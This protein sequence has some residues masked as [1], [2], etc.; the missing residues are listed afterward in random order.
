MGEF[1][2]SV[3]V[4]VR[5][6]HAS[7]YIRVCLSQSYLFESACL[8]IDGSVP[9]NLVDEVC[10]HLAGHSLV[11]HAGLPHTR[12]ETKEEARRKCR[13]HISIQLDDLL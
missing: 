2:L 10:E 5:C 9:R 3:A 11:T 4:N 1:F 12:Q 8:E 7:V 13:D 6:M